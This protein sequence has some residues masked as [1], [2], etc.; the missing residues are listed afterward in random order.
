MKRHNFLFE[1]ITSYGN[2]RRAFLKAIRGSR[3]APAVLYHEYVRENLSLSLKLPVFGKTTCG[4]PFLGFLVKEKGIY[5]L[6]KSK[7]RVAR[8]MDE[9]TAS[10]D[11]GAISE[12]K[13]AERARSVFAA[14]GL[15]RTNRLRKWVCEKG[16]RSLARTV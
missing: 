10:L 5:L 14:I 3:R 1:Q 12:E 11:S 6:R 7:R 8:R 13:A 4:L 16:E 9:I 15:A 2:I